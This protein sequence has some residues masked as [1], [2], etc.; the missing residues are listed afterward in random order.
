M[1]G[2]YTYVGQELELFSLA[3]N[4]KAYLRRR[5]RPYVFGDVLEV[6][7]GIGATTRALYEPSRHHTWTCLEPDQQIARQC[8]RRLSA[9]FASHPV[10]VIVG[11]SRDLAPGV[12]F[13]SIIY[14]DVLEHIEQDAA[15][16]QVISKRLR[17]GGC[18]VVVS[19]AHQWLFSPFDA[20]IGHFRRYNRKS[21]LGVSPPGLRVERLMYLDSVGCLA[22]AA[23]RLLLKQSSP[24]AAQIRTWDRLFVTS[25]RLL[26]PCLAYR[27]GKTIVG[28]WRRPLNGSCDV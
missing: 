23:N 12:S 4:W 1:T 11:T 20:A 28:V 15:E 17:P 10:Q 18:L 14:I 27:V 25:S 8:A 13:D 26:D 2:S 5:V 22:S 21:M 9:E 6:G 19:P 7:A 16:L 3:R 24:T